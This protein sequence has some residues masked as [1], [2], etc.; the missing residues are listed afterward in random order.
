MTRD[1]EEPEAFRVDAVTRSVCAQISEQGLHIGRGLAIV[2]GDREHPRCRDQPRP[3]RRRAP[4][5]VT[6]SEDPR[7]SRV[8]VPRDR[9]HRRSIFARPQVRRRID[10]HGQ[11]PRIA[12]LVFDFAPHGHV[13]HPRDA[14]DGSLFCD[15]IVGQF[16]AHG[17]I[18][19]GQKKK[20][21]AECRGFFADLH[22]RSTKSRRS[23]GDRSHVERRRRFVAGV[24]ARSPTR[25]MRR[26][27]LLNGRR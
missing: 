10:V 8:G 7:H 20:P 16:L 21:R 25:W 1:C 4:F 9:N 23:R 14:E 6:T 13:L 11:A 17:V 22:H 27:N 18:L 15:V 26:S 24:I 3:R 19:H 5:L 2:I 12:R